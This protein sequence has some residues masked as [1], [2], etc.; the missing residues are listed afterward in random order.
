M[1][2]GKLLGVGMSIFGNGPAVS[3]RK[4]KHVSLPKFNEGKDPLA[5]QKAIEAV[6]TAQPEAE[7]LP[8]FV[9]NGQSKASAP[10]AANASAPAVARKESLAQYAKAVPIAK[11][12]E[13]PAA[14]SQARAARQGW[15]TRL[16]PFRPPEPVARPVGEQMKLSLDAVKVVTNDLADADVDVVPVKS[17]SAAPTPAVLPPARRAWEYLGENIMKSS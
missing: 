4:N 3:Y 15:A 5:P 13:E 11:P 16:N 8:V 12:V 9:L 7:S 6:Q 1:N 14:Q 17:H 2:F 10:A